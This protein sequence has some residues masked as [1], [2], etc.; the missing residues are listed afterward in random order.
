[1]Y[2][3]KERGC[4]KRTGS[5]VCVRGLQRGDVRQNV[6]GWHRDGRS[7]CTM[8][9]NRTLHPGCSACL[10]QSHGLHRYFTLLTLYIQCPFVKQ[11]ICGIIVWGGCQCSAR[12]VHPFKQIN[13]ASFQSFFEGTERLQ[14]HCSAGGLRIV[15]EQPLQ[16]RFSWFLSQWVIFFVPNVFT[17]I[18]VTT[19]KTK[20][21]SFIAVAFQQRSSLWLWYFAVQVFVC[22]D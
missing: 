22:S 2:G 6:C 21:P 8:L 17:C 10:F 12:A 1:M 4:L 3:Y 13:I 7:A 5:R 9:S 15:M 11:K 19:G 14:R 16:K 20:A 18:S